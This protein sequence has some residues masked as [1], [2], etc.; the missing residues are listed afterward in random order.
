M[1][2]EAPAAEALPSLVPSE[3]RT[4]EETGLTDAFLNSLTLKHLYA[5]GIDSGIQVSNAMRLP[6]GGVMERIFDF[7]AQEQLVELT[8]QLAGGVIAFRR[9]A[10]APGG[11]CGGGAAAPV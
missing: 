11:P 7:L 4:V 2:E 10:P 6:W 5:E 9:T 1:P 3:P 8:S